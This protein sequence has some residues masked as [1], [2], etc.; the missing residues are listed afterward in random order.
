M[1]LLFI[2]ITSVLA[3]LGLAAVT[4]GVDSRDESGDPRRPAYP[5]GID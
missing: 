1:D 4:V 3:S 2:V 5:V